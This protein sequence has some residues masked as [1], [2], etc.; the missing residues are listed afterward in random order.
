M[1]G[2]F[3]CKQSLCKQTSLIISSLSVNNLICKIFFKSFLLLFFVWIFNDLAF[4]LGNGRK[5][6]NNIFNSFYVFLC[7]FTN[8]DT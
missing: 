4:F 2:P 3:A 1:K 6:A 7:V 8:T 5:F